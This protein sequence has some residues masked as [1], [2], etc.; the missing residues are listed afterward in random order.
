MRWIWIDRFLDFVSGKSARAV[1][2]LAPAQM[3]H[4]SVQLPQYTHCRQWIYRPD[5][6]LR[7]PFGDLTVRANMHPGYENPDCVGP[8]GPIDPAL[9]LLSVRTLSGRPIALVANYSMHYFGTPA[10]SA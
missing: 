4:A 5:R 7:D 6:M 8:Q 10:V 3:G 9:S 2:N 1:K